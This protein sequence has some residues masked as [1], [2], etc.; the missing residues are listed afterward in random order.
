[1]TFVG[2]C[3]GRSEIA[4]V[5][6]RARDTAAPYKHW[7]HSPL[8][9]TIPTSYTALKLF[10]RCYVC[11][12][13]IF[14]PTIDIQYKVCPS[15]IL[16]KIQLLV[17]FHIPLS[18]FQLLPSLFLSTLFQSILFLNVL[19]SVSVPLVSIEHFT[20]NTPLY[21]LGCTSY[22]ALLCMAVISESLTL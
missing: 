15:D 9:L 8:F 13:C 12:E 11:F 2:L 17:D 6:Q 18:R 1:M 4:L 5:I 14:T 22:N 10:S 16:K 19:L 21:C 20:K 3:H 7:N